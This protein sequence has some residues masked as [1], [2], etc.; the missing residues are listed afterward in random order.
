MILLSA[1]LAGEETVRSVVAVITGKLQSLGQN[2]S[3]VFCQWLLNS[4]SENPINGVFFSKSWAKVYFTYDWWSEHA[5]PGFIRNKW[6]LRRTWGTFF[7]PRSP[8]TMS[9][10]NRVKAKM[11]PQECKKKEK[12]Q[13]LQE[14]IA[15][16]TPTAFMSLNCAN[17]RVWLRK[18]SFFTS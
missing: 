11:Y 10:T 3:T 12:P 2:H 9:A 17:V 14:T 15:P 4:E 5:L 16:F 6:L 8:D 7:M 1:M 18:A 13:D